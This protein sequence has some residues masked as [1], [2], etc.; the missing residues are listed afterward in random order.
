[1]QIPEVCR[2]ESRTRVGVRA[3]VLALLPIRLLLGL[4]RLAGELFPNA[5]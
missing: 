1:M 3:A 5:L 2:V 4:D